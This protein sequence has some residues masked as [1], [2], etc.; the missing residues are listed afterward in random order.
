MRCHSMLL[1]VYLNVTC[2]ITLNK[3]KWGSFEKFYVPIS[4]W[5]IHNIIHWYVHKDRI[6][7]LHQLITNLCG[8]IPFVALVDLHKGILRVEGAAVSLTA[9]VSS[10]WDNVFGDDIIL[11]IDSSFPFIPHVYWKVFSLVWFFCS[12]C[13][14]SHSVIF[15]CSLMWRRVLHSFWVES[16]ILHQYEWGSV[17]CSRIMAG[18]HILSIVSK[19]Q[20]VCPDSKVKMESSS[21]M[22]FCCF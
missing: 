11:G 15:R 1:S 20:T 21:E 3:V 12:I 16:S 17:A 2:I 22:S 14:S 19:H 18:F 6:I 8:G 9:N 4:H 13:F 7:S 10:D 5:Y